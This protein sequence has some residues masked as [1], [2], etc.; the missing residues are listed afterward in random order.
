VLAA[1]SR[2]KLFALAEEI[3][4]GGGE[5]APIETDVTKPADVQ[6]LV[7]KAIEKY[8][9]IDVLFNNAGIGR[10]GWLETLDPEKDVRNQIEAN[11]LGVI[12]TAQAVLPHMIARRSGH[13]I[14]VCSM[15]GLVASPTYSIYSASKFGVHGFTQAL[16]R[17]VGIYGVRVSAIYPGG[18]KT[19]FAKE[20]VAKRKT[21]ITTPKWL[22]L[23]ADDV[24]RASLQ[25][26]RRPRR[27][28]VLPETM[29]AGYWF[30]LLFP[31]LADWVVERT[32]TI[33]ERS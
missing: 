31:G 11:L 1:R 32:F 5:A 13:I 17:E 16:R 29:R 21:G 20:A 15:G 18:V 12:W 33:P 6:N 3:Q 9:V 22:V 7:A 4:A 27:M 25:L 26:A 28:R 24:A 14:N 23:T 19:G 8:G 2:D 30:N 10:L